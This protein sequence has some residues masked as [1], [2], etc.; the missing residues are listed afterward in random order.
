MSDSAINDDDDDDLRGFIADCEYKTRKILRESNKRVQDNA[1]SVAAKDRVERLK[2]G[3]GV[4]RSATIMD[5]KSSVQMAT[6][7]PTVR[8][9]RKARTT[10]PAVKEWKGRDKI[11]HDACETIKSFPTPDT[12]SSRAFASLEESKQFSKAQRSI[13]SSLA[14]SPFNDFKGNVSKQKV[15]ASSV[16]DDDAEDDVKPAKVTLRTIERDLYAMA[17]KH[18]S[19]SCKR[20]HRL[21]PPK[22]Q[23]ND[24]EPP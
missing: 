5:R 4:D 11:I 1:R 15:A 19:A 9:P 7:S 18:N 12:N 6:P 21:L 24:A 3:G 10:T 13:H 2:Q 14:T 8:S 22:K 23:T 20:H 17:K 16:E